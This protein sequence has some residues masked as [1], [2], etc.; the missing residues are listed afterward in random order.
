MHIFGC[1]YC[2]DEHPRARYPVKNIRT[3]P[4]CKTTLPRDGFVYA[5]TFTKPGKTHVSV[6]GCT[7]CRVSRG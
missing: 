7:Q 6:V 2:F 5:R 3:C 1:P 4:S